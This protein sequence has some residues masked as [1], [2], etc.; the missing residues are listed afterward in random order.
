VQIC[1]VYTVAKQ[2]IFFHRSCIIYSGY[3]LAHLRDMLALLI[4]VYSD[5]PYFKREMK[6]SQHS[7]GL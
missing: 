2:K 4:G 5:I 6:T 7:F 3:F 1:D